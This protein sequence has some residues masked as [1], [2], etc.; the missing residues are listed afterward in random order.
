M[1][2]KVLFTLAFAVVLSAAASAQSATILTPADTQKL[3]PASVYYKGQSAP[4]Q[5]RNSGGVKFSDGYYMLASLVDVSG[6]STGVAEKYQAYFIT[7]VPLQIA[8]QNLPAGIY[9][10]GFLSSGNFVLTDVGGHTVLTAPASN[11]A[12]MRRPR[13]LEVTA[14]PGGGFRLYFGRRFVPLRR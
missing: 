6:Y 2:F 11:D 1:R 4:L 9:G 8:G 13:P 10:A 14:D 7:E 5:I 12:A 3:L